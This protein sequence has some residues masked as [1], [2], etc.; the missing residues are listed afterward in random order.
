LEYYQFSPNKKGGLR[1]SDSG[2]VTPR[3]RKSWNLATTANLKILIIMRS[4]ILFVV[5]SLFKAGV[6]VLAI[7]FVKWYLPLCLISP[8]YPVGIALL[9][10]SRGGKFAFLPLKLVGFCGRRIVGIPY[11]LRSSCRLGMCNRFW[12]GWCQAL[13]HVG[14][15]HP[16]RMLCS[17]LKFTRKKIRYWSN[18][19]RHDSV[20]SSCR[21]RRGMIESTTPLYIWNRRKSSWITP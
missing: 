7:E 14:N 12:R 11:H 20:L 1:V 2:V 6:R 17:I 19:Q 15:V 3:A 10:A 13:W 21:T 4:S 16:V 8:H 18:S 5:Y 9:L